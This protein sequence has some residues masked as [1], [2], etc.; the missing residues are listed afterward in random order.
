MKKLIYSFLGVVAAATLFTACQTTSSNNN[1]T[2]GPSFEIAASNEI[3]YL[4]GEDI[5]FS[6]KENS[7]FSSEEGTVTYTITGGDTSIAT[8]TEE[9]VLSFTGSGAVTVSG[10]YNGDVSKNSV[11]VYSLY[12][13]EVLS[14]RITEAMAQSIYLGLTLD[15]GINSY[16]APFYSV[17]NG[18]GYVEIN[19]NGELEFIGIKLANDRLRIVEQN[20]AV[21]YE[22]M[23]CMEHSLFTTQIANSL[24]QSG[25]LADLYTDAPQETFASVAT[26]HLANSVATLENYHA[27]SYF[28]SLVTL[29]LSNA[30]LFDLSFLQN[31]P[32]IKSLVLDHNTTLTNVDNGLTLYN[33]FEKLSNLEKLSIIGSFSCFDRTSYNMLTSI[34]KRQNL[35]L[36]VSENILLDKTNI[37]A[38]SECVFFSI[39]EYQ[40]HINNNNGVI[41]PSEGFSFAVLC[42]VNDQSKEATAYYAIDASKLSALDLYGDERGFQT[43]IHTTNDLILNLHDYKLYLG[44]NLSIDAITCEKTLV[45]NAIRG[46]CSITA[47]QSVWTKSVW[48]TSPVGPT[49]Y[50]KKLISRKA[51][52]ADTVNLS[53]TS[54]AQLYIYGAN[55]AVGGNG[56][57]DG[58]NPDDRNSKKWGCWGSD[59]AVG[60]SAQIVNFRA[61]NITVQGGNGGRGGN[62]GDGSNANLLNKGYDGGHGG[63]GG[64][65][66]PALSCKTYSIAEGCSTTLLGGNAGGGGNGGKPY[67]LGIAGNPGSAGSKASSVE[68]R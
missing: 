29:D 56:I 68:Y 34:V 18:E 48:E 50:M 54:N 30:N 16:T 42:L 39:E 1:S 55:G 31:C 11:T 21:L 19:E 17:D 60:I 26:L 37:Q 22:G 63:Y 62:G 28:T 14:E 23:Y 6:V 4:G 13:N 25:I 58:S 20:Q 67:A 8:L 2:G 40:T 36:S 27:L 59:G 47:S 43:S 38:F 66:A 44:S 12:P 53:T 61:G 5:T 7:L 45:V 65:G 57:A 32:T 46:I 49:P 33:T 15:V 41:T 24:V 3:H 64:N 51:I 9:G 10:V 52:S 35:L